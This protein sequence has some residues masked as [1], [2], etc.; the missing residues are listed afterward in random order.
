MDKIKKE[1][2]FSKM[3]ISSS[4]G[5]LAYG[6]LAFTAWRKIKKEKNRNIEDEEK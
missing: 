6:D 4:L 3:P 1:I 5:H 2:D